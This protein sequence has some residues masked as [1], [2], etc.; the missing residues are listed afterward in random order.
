MSKCIIAGCSNP[1]IHNLGVRL[2]RPDTTAVWAPN[3]EGYLCDV[4]AKQGMM[5]TIFLEPNQSGT[6]KTRIISG[7]PLSRTTPINNDR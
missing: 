2:R 5:I 3:T 6:I 1:G 4:H 7:D